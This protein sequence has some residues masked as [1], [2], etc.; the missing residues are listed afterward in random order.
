M[1]NTCKN[2]YKKYEEL[3]NYLIVG[4]LTTVVSLFIYYGSVLTFLNPNHALELQIAN[5]LSWIG[6][7]AFAYV[8]NRT[9][10]FKSKN[11]NKLGSRTV[12]RFPCG[13]ALDGYGS[14]VAA[15][16]RASRKR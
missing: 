12:C 16:D 4:V 6:A 7:V 15:G 14:H 13:N 8:T 5:I 3:I 9:F 10:V 2:L 11:Q 1:W